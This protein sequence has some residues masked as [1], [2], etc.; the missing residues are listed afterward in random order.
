MQGFNLLNSNENE[1]RYPC[2]K[3]K[4]YTKSFVDKTYS[5]L[6]PMLMEYFENDK[7]I[8]KRR[9]QELFHILTHKKD[10]FYTYDLE[11]QQKGVIKAG[12]NLTD[13]LAVRYSKGVPKAMVLIE[14]KSTRRACM[15][16][17]GSKDNPGIETHINGMKE[18]IKSE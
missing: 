13:M 8:E 1:L 5:I 4:N 2:I 15:D 14:V 11:Q 7:H 6:L 3:R 9:Q 16:K 17:I 12:Q 10:G 18:Y